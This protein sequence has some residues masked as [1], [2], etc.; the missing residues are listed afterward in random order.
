M[1]NVRA[2]LGLKFFMVLQ[3]FVSASQT[4]YGQLYSICSFKGI[5][6]S[7]SHRQITSDISKFPTSLQSNI[8]LIFSVSF[9]RNS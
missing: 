3:I 1:T 5:L 4:G 9:S 8:N 6:Q 2:V 7:H